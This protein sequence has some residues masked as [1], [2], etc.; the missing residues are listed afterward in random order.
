LT[1]YYIHLLWKTGLIRN[2]KFFDLMLCQIF[3]LQKLHNLGIQ[4]ITNRLSTLFEIFVRCFF[5]SYEFEKKYGKLDAY[6][7]NI[8]P[9]WFGII[10]LA[11]PYRLRQIPHTNPSLKIKHCS[12]AISHE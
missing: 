9:A 8:T 3:D 4:F 12:Q 7:R 5:S 11:C 6:A 10:S 2:E 1:D